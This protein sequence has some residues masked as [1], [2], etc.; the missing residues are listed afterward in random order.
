MNVHFICRG[1][2]HRS[3]MAEAYL[4]SLNLPGVTVV[5]SGTVAD[6]YREPN[7]KSLQETLDFLTARGIGQ[8]AKASSEQLTQ[9]RFHQND[10]TVCVNQ[11][12]YD[13]GSQSVTFPSD[14]I[15]WDISD[16]NEGHRVLK[17]G[18]LPTMYDD[19]I[20]QQIKTNIDELVKKLSLAA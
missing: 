8:Y 3:V 16:T 4:K 6:L 18:D 15:V 20:F 12:A 14:T 5:S 19:E 13:E 11:I 10:V 17:P 2:A 1:N 9:E 7:R